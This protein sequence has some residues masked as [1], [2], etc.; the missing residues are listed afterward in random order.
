MR[1]RKRA[2]ARAQQ[3]ERDKETSR[4]RENK[5]KSS[6]AREKESKGQYRERAIELGV[7]G[8]Y[9]S[10]IDG[11][12]LLKC[13]TKKTNVL[14]K[15][16]ICLRSLEK[17]EHCNEDPQKSLTCRLLCGCCV[18]VYRCQHLSEVAG[19]SAH[20]PHYQ[21]AKSTSKGCCDQGCKWG[22]EIEENQCCDNVRLFTPIFLRPVVIIWRS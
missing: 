15:K 12:L 17:Q 13:S 22:R 21:V 16:P 19:L 20:A 5:R 14:Q 10:Y 7:G 3:S 1:A 18:C 9:R 2:R 11:S 6:R 4:K 8:R